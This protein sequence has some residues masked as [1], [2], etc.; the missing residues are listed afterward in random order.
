MVAVQSYPETA[1]NVVSRKSK[2]RMEG[3]IPLEKWN[4]CDGRGRKYDL[5]RQSLT[6]TVKLLEIEYVFIKRT[7]DSF[8]VFEAWHRLAHKGTRT[9]AKAVRDGYDDYVLGFQVDISV[10]YHLLYAAT[11]FVTNNEDWKEDS[12]IVNGMIGRTGCRW[13]SILR[14]AHG[15]N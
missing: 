11:D 3:V 8:E 1:A 9:S 12:D 10:L 4:F 13:S 2:E 14:V 15:Q 7:V 6:R 5:F